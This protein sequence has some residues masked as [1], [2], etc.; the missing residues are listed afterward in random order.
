M[1]VGENLC[2]E[3]CSRVLQF[4]FLLRCALIALSCAVLIACSRDV[5][6]MERYKQP[7]FR[8]QKPGF[9]EDPGE[10]QM[11]E[12]CAFSLSGTVIWRAPPP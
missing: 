4:F 1:R 11:K 3:G 9:R 2:S 8:S 6:A 10:T 12:V 7:C 5:R